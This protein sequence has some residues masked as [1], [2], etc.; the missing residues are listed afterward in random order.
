MTRQRFV[1]FFVIWMMTFP[2]WVAADLP[3]GYTFLAFGDALRE[4]EASGKPV[5]LYLTR[6]GCAFCRRTNEESFAKPEVR[7][8]YQKHYVLASIDTES[9]RRVTLPSGERTTDMQLATQMRVFGT[10]TFLFL[11]P[12]QSVIHKATGFQTVADLLALDDYVGGG[13]YR[14]VK[15]F[16]EFVKARGDAKGK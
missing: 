6:E 16:A 2:G 10:P 7:D 1:M 8:R 15:S 14:Q 9:D 12:D 4:A 5:F 13:A 3:A 11:R